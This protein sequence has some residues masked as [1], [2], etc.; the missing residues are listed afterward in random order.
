MVKNPSAMWETRV[1]SLGQKDPREKEMVIH[2]CVLA[3]EIPQ[4]EKPGELPFI[5]LQ[6]IKYDFATK[7]Y[8]I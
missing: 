5:G 4:T 7:S 8:L 2:S 3:W 6:R 1:Q